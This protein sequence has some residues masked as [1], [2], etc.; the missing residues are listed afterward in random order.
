VII[1]KYSSFYILAGHFFGQQTHKLL[2]PFHPTLFV[3]IPTRDS[4]IYHWTLAIDLLGLFSY[5]FL[6]DVRVLRFFAAQ[7]ARTDNW[8]L[9]G[10]SFV[11][12]AQTKWFEVNTQ[13]FFYS[14]LFRSLRIHLFGFL[15]TT[16]TLEWPRFG[17]LRLDLNSEWPRRDSLVLEDQLL[18]KLTIWP[19]GLDLL[20]LLCDCC[21]DQRQLTAL[22]LLA[23]F[24]EA[25]VLGRVAG[26]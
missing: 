21:F 15:G 17:S 2:F 23:F 8:Q 3:F 16:W 22:L 4:N 18:Q 6:E 25:F 24:V 14:N 13:L 9:S 11:S 20:D 10:T 7:S 19:I 12:L 5:H 1:L 26:F